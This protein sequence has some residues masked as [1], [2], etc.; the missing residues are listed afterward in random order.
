M[1]KPLIEFELQD[2]FNRT[3]SRR[4]FAGKVVAVI[5]SDYESMMHSSLSLHNYVYM[6]G[7]GFVESWAKF[8]SECSGVDLLSLADLSAVPS[9]A[10]SMVLA[11]SFTIK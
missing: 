4:S 7:K 11:H 9:F 10:R 3:Y 2:Q 6:L 1:A 5:S 8:I